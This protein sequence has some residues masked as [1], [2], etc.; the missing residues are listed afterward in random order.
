[1]QIFILTYSRN[2]PIQGDREAYS[3][4]NFCWFKAFS[5]ASP[6]VLGKYFSSRYNIICLIGG[7]RKKAGVMGPRA[8]LPTAKFP[9]AK[10]TIAVDDEC[11]AKFSTFYRNY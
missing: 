10:V 5:Y 2:N 6:E 4:I 7:N 8:E 9:E 11:M 1:M 3:I